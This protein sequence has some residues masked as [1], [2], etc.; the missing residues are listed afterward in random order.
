MEEVRIEYKRLVRDQKGGDCLGNQDVDGRI[1][2][3][4]SLKKQH[5]LVMMWTGFSLFRIE[6]SERL[7]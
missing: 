1:I 6:L 5:I 7:S 2:L 4:L 3:K